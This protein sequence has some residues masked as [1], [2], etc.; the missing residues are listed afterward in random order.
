MFSL[1]PQHS[2]LWIGVVGHRPNGLVGADNGLL[3]QRVRRV[4]EHA[5]EV[6]EAIAVVSPLAEGA[7]RVVAREALAAG[8]PLYCLLPFASDEYAVDFQSP[9]SL[10]EY[11]HLLES[12]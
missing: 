11:H 9:S 5:Q 7:D 6:S 12:A 2:L 8:Y 10:A 4:F 1:S 3:N